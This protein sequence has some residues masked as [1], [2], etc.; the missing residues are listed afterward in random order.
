MK[1]LLQELNSMKVLLQELNSTKS[2]LTVTMSSLNFI[3][4]RSELSSWLKKG[5]VNHFV[6]NRFAKV[7]K[8]IENMVMITLS[9]VPRG[10]W[11][12]T[13]GVLPMDPKACGGG[14]LG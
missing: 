5:V 1:L 10:F 2:T 12:T 6:E 9:T 11:R 14:R 3:S 13:Y 8:L 7:I 4:I